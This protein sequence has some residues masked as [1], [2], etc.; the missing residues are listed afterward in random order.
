MSTRSSKRRERPATGFSLQISEKV[1]IQL[2]LAV[3]MVTLVFGLGPE[4]AS[5]VLPLMRGGTLKS[6][7]R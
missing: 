7:I 5:K 2:I 3:V 6:A 1:S 4:V